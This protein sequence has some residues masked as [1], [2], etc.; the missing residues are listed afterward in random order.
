MTHD[1]NQGPP[2]CI[3]K[4]IRLT[5][6]MQAS[7]LL[8]NYHPTTQG[9]EKE[10]MAKVFEVE[11]NEKAIKIAHQHGKTEKKVTE[12]DQSRIVEDV[13]EMEHREHKQVEIQKPKEVNRQ[14][15]N[16][17]LSELFI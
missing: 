10:K 12:A 9:I 2:Q 16:E 1:L 17:V 5:Q 3:V 7:E 15:P 11:D 6:V 14:T 13:C 8:N 4:A